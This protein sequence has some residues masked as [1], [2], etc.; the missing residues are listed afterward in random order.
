[1]TIR[2]SVLA[3]CMKTARPAWYGLSGIGVAAVVLFLGGRDEAAVRYAGTLLQLAGL[4]TVAWGLRDMRR[5]FN[6][7][8]IWRAVLTW[9][10]TLATAFMSPR[11]VVVQASEILSASSALTAKV[12]VGPR[13]DA[14]VEER[15]AALERRMADLEAELQNATAGLRQQIGGLSEGAVDERRE[16]ELAGRE[17]SHRIETV[18]VGGLRLEM[19]GLA[20]LVVGVLCTSIPSEIAGLICMWR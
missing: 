17:I 2:W 1:M 13:P 6:R 14:S 11:H 19:V 8:S 15:V 18:A 16:R 12:T 20:W 7:P 5:L 4:F 10:K 3:D 9:F